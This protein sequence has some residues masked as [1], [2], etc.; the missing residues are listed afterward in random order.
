MTD[1]WDDLSKKA[2]IE[3]LKNFLPGDLLKRY[4]EKSIIFFEEQKILYNIIP[5]KK[6]GTKFE[7][8]RKKNPPKK[9]IL[10]HRSKTI[11]PTGAIIEFLDNIFDNYEKSLDK[12]DYPLEILLKF[13]SDEDEDSKNLLIKENSG[14]IESGDIDPLIIMGETSQKGEYQ[15]GTWG[16]AFLNSVISLSTSAEVYTNHIDGIPIFMQIPEEFFTNDEW[17][18]ECDTSEDLNALINLDKGSTIMIFKNINK[19]TSNDILIFQELINDIQDTFWKKVLKLKTIGHDVILRIQPYGLEVLTARF[20]PI[21]FERV[22]SHYPYCPPIYLKDYK[23]E[24]KDVNGNPGEILVDVYCGINPFR[25]EHP[26]SRYKGV[27]MFG[28]G[29]KFAN[30]LDDTTVG[31]GTD[32]T[33]ISSISKRAS[34]EMLSIFLFFKSKKREWNEYI[35]WNIPTK[36]GYNFKSELKNHIL[37]LISIVADRFIF[38][39]KQLLGGR[40]FIFKIFTYDFIEKNMSEK[41]NEFQ[42]F[43]T[44]RNTYELFCPD[45]DGRDL[46]T[47]KST[48]SPFYNL[49]TENLEEIDRYNASNN[50]L[51]QVKIHNKDFL[52]NLKIYNKTLYQVKSVKT[53]L[54]DAMI[55]D[56]TEG[57]FLPSIESEDVLKESEEIDI[58]LN[59][60]AIEEEVVSVLKKPELNTLD[61][62]TEKIDSDLEPDMSIHEPIEE[63]SDSEV[64]KVKVVVPKRAV[65]A[66][67]KTIKKKKART[68]R[69][70]AASEKAKD[71]AKSAKKKQPTT[72]IRFLLEKKVIEK[73]R[74]ICGLEKD[75]SNSDLIKN[76]IKIFLKSGNKNE[77]N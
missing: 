42:N 3:R 37:E 33:E 11:G 27:W 54:F 22:F 50:G 17:E 41:V 69:L 72:W 58:S 65:P 12:I 4:P 49:D 76:V 56:F 13:Y 46:E 15:I 38:P 52:K 53:G 23:I 9:I 39:L 60:E 62:S 2:K 26:Y 35:P 34:F 59:S 67:K 75:V 1:K 61:T 32:E 43:I 31:F 51:E 25:G 45:I 68:Q 30:N 63:V 48:F 20:K 18:L 40:E 19:Y 66:V 44:R 5:R 8:V 6:E 57:E 14:G 10:K 64:K 28:N 77:D 55:E 73:L 7:K 47:V 71:T 36:I 70:K 29:R 16:E 24:F 74:D 21:G